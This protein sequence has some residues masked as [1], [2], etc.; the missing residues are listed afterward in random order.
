[1]FLAR[2]LPGVYILMLSILLGSCS[3]NVMQTTIFSDGFQ[4][5]EEGTVPFTDSTDP[6]IYFNSNRGRLGGWNT[7]TSLRQPGFSTAWQIQQEEGV[8]YLAQTFRNLDEQ[9]EPLSLI[10]H[11]ML[12]A[13]DSLWKD[14]TIDAVFTPE[15]KFD[16]CGILFSYRNPSD[17]YFF[18]IEGNTII[19]KL[20]QPSVTPL[21]PFERILEYRPVVWTPGDRFHVAVTIRRNNIYASVNDTIRM[22]VEDHG[23][24]TGRI[25]LLSDNPARFHSVEVKMLRGEQRKL[26]RRRRQIQRRTELRLSDHPSMAKWRSFQ[27]SGFG[28]DQNIRLGDLTG[29]GNKEIV[30]VRRDPLVPGSAGGLS[31]MNLEGEILWE[32]GRTG[33]PYPGPG[34]ELPVQA[35]DLDGDGQRDVIFA[36]NGWIQIL[37]GRSG[38]P[39]ERR[40]IPGN[41]EPVSMLFGDLLGVGRDNCI[42]LSDHRERLVVLNEN[43]ELI[44][45]Q[46]FEKGSHPMVHDMDGDGHHDVLMGYSLF[47]SNGE[48]VMNLG[49]F[50]GDRCNGVSVFELASGETSVASLVYAAGDWGLIF[51]DLDGNLL[52][53]N[54]MGHVENLSLADFDLQRPGLELVTANRWGSDGLVHMV[55]ASGTILRDLMLD[56]GVSRC[57]P[58]NWKGD[59]EE[60]FITS[61]DTLLGGMFDFQGQL[62]VSFPCDGHPATCYM[63]Q[64]LTGDARDEVLVWDHLQLWIYTQDDNPRMGK[65]YAPRRTPVYN[66]STQQVNRSLPDW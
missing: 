29:D 10:T 44:W 13:G 11:P 16:K 21:R 9:N 15:T 38:K 43:F 17:F 22:Y 30:L 47:T 39:V 54:I 40:K 19:L 24:G 66:Y 6:A 64:D 60:F 18:G 36:S 32:Y 50:I 37:D 61:A 28:T 14:I 20:V 3:G 45:Q 35:H 5:L 51:F 56:C 48:R 52:K 26:N 58:V 62:A 8:N 42:V 7:A 57:V 53:Q 59:G 4:E 25:G 41:L 63:V 49:A 34:G 31:V 2:S 23:H 46:E 12:I 27:T 55:D 1:M 33:D 65:T